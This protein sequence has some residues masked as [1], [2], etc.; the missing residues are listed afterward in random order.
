LFKA[1]SEKQIELYQYTVDMEDAKATV[2]N[3]I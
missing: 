1:Y 3:N 2:I